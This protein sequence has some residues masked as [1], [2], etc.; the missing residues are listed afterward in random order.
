MKLRNKPS[1]PRRKKNIEYSL[2]CSCYT[3]A[4]ILNEMRSLL[5][6]NKYSN[7]EITE[8]LNFSN[9]TIEQEYDYDSHVPVAILYADEAN[10]AFIERNKEYLKK[11]ASYDEWYDNNRD[12]IEAEKEKRLNN[13]KLSEKEK[14]EKEMKRLKK[15]MEKLDAD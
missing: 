13:A 11:L 9:I 1:K 8:Y 6:R 10:I 2:Q 15:K 7:D 5:E 12:E 4:E 14:L 3:L